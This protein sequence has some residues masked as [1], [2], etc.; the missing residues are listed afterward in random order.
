MIWLSL[1]AAMAAPLEVVVQQPHSGQVE[2]V[3]GNHAGGL[4]ASGGRDSS[5]R[6]WHTETG[7]LIRVFDGHT[8][9]VRDVAFTPDDTRL[10]SAGDKR[11]I[12]WNVHTGEVERTLS[13]EHDVHASTVSPDGK[14]VATGGSNAVH[15]YDLETGEKLWTAT[16]HENSISD[17]G[18]SPDGKSLASASADGTVRIWSARSG[19][20]IRI[21]D[22][23]EDGVPTVSWHPSGKRLASGDY[24]GTVHI[25]TATSGSIKASLEVHASAQ[26]LDFSPDGNELVVARWRAELPEQNGTAVIWNPKSGAT[27]ELS[28]GSS[29]ALR[30]VSYVD[31]GLMGTASSDGI[32]RLWDVSGRQLR[33]FAGEV[34]K[35]LDAAVVP[36]GVALVGGSRNRPYGAVWDLSLGKIERQLVGHTTAIGFVSARADGTLFTGDWNSEIRLWHPGAFEPY[37]VL[38]LGGGK[39][40]AIRGGFVDDGIWAVWRDQFATWP[41]GDEP[42][43]S[44]T[45]ENQKGRATVR[46]GRMATTR[47]DGATL[48]DFPPTGFAGRIR[49]Q[50]DVWAL[51][52]APDGKWLALGAGASVQLWENE[53]KRW[54]REDLFDKIIRDVSWSSTGDTLAV[55]NGDGT[56]ALLD[57]AD[58]SEVRRL[59]GHTGVVQSVAFLP[60]DERLLTSS[61]DGTARLWDRASGEQ[62]ALLIPV[63]AADYAIVTAD[64]YYTIT[65]A[66]MQ[67]VHF[68]RG[69]EVFTFDNFDLRYNRP[70]HVIQTL[71]FAEPAMVRA[72][73]GA[74]HRRVEK[75]G[76]SE[77]DLVGDV[78][79]PTVNVHSSL[80]LE[81]TERV[82]EVEVEVEDRVH[83]LDRLNAYV[84]G[85]PV[86]GIAGIPLEENKSR[87][88]LEIPLSTGVNHIQISAHNSRGLES[89]RHTLEVT[90]RAPDAKPVV[91]L[92]AVG[93]SDYRGEDF[94]LTYAAKDARDVIDALAKHTSGP[95]T[96]HILTD[97]NAT[98][99]NVLALRSVLEATHVD[100]MVVVFFAG[101]G[102]LDASLNYVFATHETDFA[103]PAG[104]GLTYEDID[105]LLDGIPARQ[106]LLL[107][108]TCHSGEVEADV[109]VFAPVGEAAGGMVKSRG[110]SVV[111]KQPGPSPSEVGK[112]LFADLRR[113]TGA[114]VIASASGLELAFESPAWNNGVFTYAMLEGLASGSADLNADNAIAVSEL[115]SYVLGQVP[116]LTGGLQAPNVRQDNLE[117]DFVLVR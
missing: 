112:E 73:R 85:V 53:T 30:G 3:V 6:L 35:L 102:M 113:G 48:W 87:R 103:A 38:R 42:F 31:T 89:L 66:A 72:Y 54:S 80:P 92:V 97:A 81:T 57:S 82:V 26:S 2:V 46:Q 79:V 108:D 105:G 95:V 8:G 78:S 96:T 21:F 56:V 77:Q 101:H 41:G 117:H 20:A 58:G 18:F 1:C 63:G 32:P 100:D 84:N 59:F 28:V 88:S 61:D 24:T 86:F 44:L 64:G 109:A 40:D 17:L 13:G 83:S 67:R 37:K 23:H 104:T 14:Q 51:S 9:S 22:A 52:F 75:M 99:D 60:G 114:V 91:H 68:V 11:V 65:P 71:G 94:D 7:R 34:T 115:R 62:V 15:L 76:F 110:L 27:R 45:L 16:G 29:V 50:E 33:A 47:E 90:L 74:W 5:I 4:V 106:R 55:A 49:T 111:Q 70:D 43:T 25:W 12:V 19:D 93:V 116:L 39:R 69:I 98:R 36:T 10:V 107:L